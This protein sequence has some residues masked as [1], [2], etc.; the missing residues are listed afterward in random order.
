M[1]LNVLPHSITEWR[2]KKMLLVSSTTFDLSTMSCI[3]NLDGQSPH[4]QVPA[5]DSDGC[6]WQWQ[7]S[8]KAKIKRPD[9]WVLSYREGSERTV[10]CLPTSCDLALTHKK[11]AVI[12]PYSGH[13]VQGGTS[14]QH[15]S[16]S[17]CL[18][19]TSQVLDF[20]SFWFVTLCINTN[21][22][23]WQLLTSSNAGSV[24]HFPLTCF[25]LSRR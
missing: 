11:L 16:T 17:M 9:A 22:L 19:L 14:S 25:R 5:I 24:I 6:L 18:L 8:D 12:K 10:E 4:L 20:S 13:L 1:I 21:A 7:V 23:S 15:Q 3:K 2:K